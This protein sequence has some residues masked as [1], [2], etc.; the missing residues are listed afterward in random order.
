[1][2][3]LDMRT[4]IL[5]NVVTDVVCM[6]VVLLLWHQSRN[7]F[8][9]I[10]FW[11]LDFVFQTA[12]MFLVILRGSLPDVI[13]V[14]LANTLVIAGAILGYAGFGR[15]V[16]KKIP[17]LHNY[18]LLAVFACVHAYFTL[19]QPNLPPRNL[20]VSAAML[21][22]CFQCLWFLAYRVEPGMRRFTLGAGMVF[23]G[24]CLVSVFRIAG[25][26]M[27][28]AAGKDFF[29]S[30]AF[31]SIMLISYQMLFI[32]LTYSL[33]LM[34]NKRLIAEVETEEEK[35]AK[36]F[37]SSPYAIVLTRL[38]D[39]RIIEVNDGFL[40]IT[41][42]G[43][44]E[45]IGKT[46]VGLH[47]W[48]REEDRLTA[49]QELSKNGKVQGKE[50][51]FRKKSGE[52]ITGLFSAEI[53][54]INK[55]DCVLSS[56]N[57]ITERKQAE[58]ELRNSRKFLEIANTYGSLNPLL[59]EF[60]R[61]IK[62]STGCD[63]VG[64]RLLDDDGNIPYMAY[65]GFPRQ[66]YEA[67]SPL[68]IKS[69]HCMCINVV[70][71]AT[72]PSLPFYTEG[73]SFY[74]NGTTRFLSTVSEAEKGQTRNMCNQAGYESVALIPIRVG[75]R[76]LGLVHIADG[77]ANR[78]PVSLIKLLEQAA[79]SLG[80]GIQRALAEEALR[81]SEQRWATTLKSIGDAVIAADS[82]GRITF[83]NPVAEELTGWGLQDSNQKP[84][85]E[86]F[87]IINEDTRQ[88]VEDPVAKVLKA[89]GIVGLANHTILVRKDGVEVPIDDS[90]A[91]ITDPEGKVTG[92]VLVFRDITE[93]KRTED[94]LREAHE[95]AGWLARFPAENP[96]PVMRVSA[97]GSV[98]FC[99]PAAA[100]LPGWPSEI[101]QTLPQPVLPLVRRAM[102]EERDV[103]QDVE[104][105]GR[106]YSVRVSPFLTENYVN[107]YGLDITERKQAEETV[108]KERDFSGAVLDTAGAL[109]IVLDREGR[110]TRFNR[111]CEALTRYSAAE[112][113]GRVF[114]DFLIPQE[115]LQG[116]M[117]TWK[118]LRAGNFP[119]QHENHWMVKDG[120][121]RLI[122]WSNTALV[123]PQG[124]IEH[125]IAT[126]ED[127][128][129]RRHME[130]EIRRSRDEL[131]IKVQERTAE[132][133]G[134]NRELQEE[135]NRREKAEQQLRQAQ[136]MEAIGTLAG[137]IAHDL[138]NI[139][140]PIVINSELALMN[141]D[142]NPEIRNHLDLTLR[143]GLRGKDLVK[144]LLLFSRKSEKKQEIVSLIP[145]V[146]DTFKLLRASIPS[147]VGMELRLKTD[148]DQV[149][150]DPSQ[151]QQ[152][153]M[154]LCA[155]AAYSIRGTVGSIDICVEGITFGPGDLPEP[156]MDPGDYLVLS[157][158]DTGCG[159]D[160]E[161][162]MRVFEPLFT[163]KPAGV[164]TG[165]GL[166]VVHGIV[167]SHQ[168][169]ITVYSEPGKGSI[170]KV[171]L[172][173]V[174]TGASVKIEPSK[175]IPRGSERILLVDDEE[176][177]VNSVRSMLQHLGYQVTALMDSRETLR[178]FSADP[179]QFDL[180]M[181]DQTMPFLTGENLAKEMMRIR[182]DI[183]VILCTGYADLI[184]ADRAKEMGF[185]GF[186][187]K[188]FTVREGAELVRRVLDQKDRG[189]S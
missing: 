1:M 100:K 115:E 106:F 20:N 166:S 44:G 7:R 42:Y 153:I 12:A 78:V 131:E 158:K 165:L 139:L 109:V 121:R 38:S 137:G 117:R 46:T 151:I 157:V 159:M 120:S 156:D 181:T 66:F 172:P 80:V 79:S 169:N 9:G 26:F 163:T 54:P 83:I 133:A 21:I 47:L 10:G 52:I 49:V 74:M 187:M 126:G 55:Q 148:S 99:N 179:S 111:A 71:G 39:G 125:I 3:S 14:V 183:P 11:V 41:G 94:R 143:S 19:I 161:V 136:K 150:G 64:I 8:A 127:I 59:Q 186:L 15:F 142:G 170:F 86:V 67:E 22:I 53:I 68:S 135:M 16:G 145:L 28:T 123:G 180:V 119:N 61:E 48:G 103:E 89:G 129:D 96:N 75:S 13:S 185:Q 112:V 154:N 116:V 40:N 160:E 146:N 70:K 176:F 72:D 18:V 105:R 23:G 65:S 134:A 60:V 76:I 93:R 33:V 50:F 184:A 56:I 88:K 144:Q 138:N 110:I 118:A 124:E 140:G 175:P 29:K 82:T 73:G 24:Y 87:R 147:T 51:E 155:N 62:E 98:L 141:L 57:D 178:F 45:A 182:P 174:D 5:S 30:G 36:G 58:T 91:P 108:R 25:L 168:G 122:A 102:T 107:I 167:K 77:K 128:T 171:Y 17:Q 85:A 188:P 164:G 97:D 189:N 152:V 2:F 4:V 177:I 69:D 32:L 130:E 27:G 132:L 84:V 114:W 149:S 35:F 101:G 113:I 173:K 6:L 104:V 92:V 95:R 37:R 43:Y 63:A 31:E 81:R 162:R 90:G 34:V